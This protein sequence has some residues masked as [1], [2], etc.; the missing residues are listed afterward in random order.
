M[1]KKILITGS[2]SKIAKHLIKL[3]PKKIKI[4]KINSKNFKL[5]NLDEIKKNI[6]FFEQFDTVFFFHSEIGTERLN[7]NNLE[8]ISRSININ[9][10]SQIYISEI[11]LKNHKNA[12]I[13]F[14]GSESGL[15]GSYDIIYSLMKTSIH[16]YV[17]ERK[18]LFPNQKVLCLAPSTITDSI[19]TNKRKD[20]KNVKNSIKLNPKK[21][22]L[23]S[24]EIAEII[25]DMMFS[26]KF[27]Y[28]TNTII[29]LNGGKFARM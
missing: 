6:K 18:I 7:F 28:L 9:L 16:K 17:E 23:Y 14:T 13:F 21:R 25:F 8:K 15:K 2:N 19:F 27:N 10:L 1:S 3:I 29:H 4:Q 11:C 24:K 12:K 20:Q 22:G 5:E 26:K